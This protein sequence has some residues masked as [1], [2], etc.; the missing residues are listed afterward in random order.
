MY[1]N[2]ITVRKGIGSG[3]HIQRKDIEVDIP[4]HDFELFKKHFSIISKIIYG[5]DATINLEF[6]EQHGTIIELLDDIIRSSQKRKE[7]VVSIILG[8]N[9]ILRISEG[10]KEKFV[11][12]ENGEINT[13]RGYNIIESDKKDDVKYNTL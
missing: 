6:N 7:T 2:E 8:K 9:Q 12:N 13:Y 5:E 11:Y 4:E 10:E 1:I 3:L